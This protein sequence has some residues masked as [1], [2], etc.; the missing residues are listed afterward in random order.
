MCRPCLPL[1]HGSPASASKCWDYSP[2]PASYEVFV[3]RVFS[4]SSSIYNRYQSMLI[5]RDGCM[6]IFINFT[7]SI[8]ESNSRQNKTNDRTSISG[9]AAVSKSVV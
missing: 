6:K 7:K 1:T 3:T 4:S 5:A 8:Q 9:H 2:D